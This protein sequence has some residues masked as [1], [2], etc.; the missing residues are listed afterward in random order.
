[1]QGSGAAV[2]LADCAGAAPRR[3]ATAPQP[4]PA[5]GP[6]RRAG[7][8]PSLEPGKGVPPERTPGGL[9]RDWDSALRRAVKR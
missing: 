2:L 4:P 5:R 1:M 3:Q 9:D 6:G 8:V 7:Q